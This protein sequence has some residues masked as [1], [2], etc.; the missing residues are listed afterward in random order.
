MGLFGP[1]HGFVFENSL[2]L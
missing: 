2:K 1:Q